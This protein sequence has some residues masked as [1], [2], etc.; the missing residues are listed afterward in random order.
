MVRINKYSLFGIFKLFSAADIYAYFGPDP[1][2]MY[3]SFLGL[4]IDDKGK[5]IQKLLDDILSGAKLISCNFD[6]QLYF[7][8]YCYDSR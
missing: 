8:Y 3:N 4:F 7:R 2:P 5:Y 1:F 6:W